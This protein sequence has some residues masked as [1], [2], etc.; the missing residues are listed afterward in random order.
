MDRPAPNRARGN[1]PGSTP[2]ESAV[3]FDGATA[4]QLL[5]LVYEELRHLAAR[6]L[7]AERPDHTLQPTALVHEAYL[8]LAAGAEPARNWRGSAHF[9]A[10]AAEAMRRILID[11]A[12]RRSAVRHGGNHEQPGGDSALAAV[13]SPA[14]SPLVDEAEELL[15]LDAALSRLEAEDRPKAEL[16]KLHYFGGLSLEDAADALAISRATAYR[17]WTYARAWL[18]D[19][20]R[21]R[22]P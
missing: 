10:A 2:G 5:P 15:A 13:A 20:V 9:F 18:R 8:R 7:A 12:R 21:G 11:N 22:N 16:V 6:K 14:A 4:A 17:H 3:E 19:R 1:P